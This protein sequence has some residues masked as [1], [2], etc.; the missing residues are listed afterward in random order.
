MKLIS[1]NRETVTIIVEILAG[2]F[3]FCNTF[4]GSETTF[5]A[6]GSALDQLVR[7]FSDIYLYTMIDHFIG[8]KT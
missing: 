6:L 8:R 3:S 2:R 1:L 4:P 7:L 5:Q